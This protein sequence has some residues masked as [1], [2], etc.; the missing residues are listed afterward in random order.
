MKNNPCDVCRNELL[1]E[2]KDKHGWGVCGFSDVMIDIETLGTSPNAAI[3]QIAAVRFDPW[4]R[5][6]SSPEGAFN[7]HARLTGDPLIDG[8]LEWSTVQ[9]WLRQSK[10]AQQ[11]V[12]QPTT[13]PKDHIGMRVMALVAWLG[14]MPF[15]RVWASGPQFDLVLLKRTFERTIQA[16][17]RFQ[18]DEPLRPWPISYKVERDFRTLREVGY[19][20]GVPE[21]VRVGVAHD[22][23][24]D[25]FHQ[26]AWAIEIL[27]AVNAASK[28]GS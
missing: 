2:E 7:F 10:E 4:T 12:F 15:K 22:A 26:V 11:R 18:I 5:R 24:D 3:V 27:N 9:W 6:I 8:D 25:C 28:P 16:L 23:L 14:E 13:P 19:L 1:S 21:P 17:P 20:L